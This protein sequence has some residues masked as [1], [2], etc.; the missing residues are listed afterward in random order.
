MAKHLKP[1]QRVTP[2]VLRRTHITMLVAAGIDLITIWSMVGHS[3][4]AMTQRYSGV[5]MESKHAALD[6]LHDLADDA[7]EGVD[8]AMIDRAMGLA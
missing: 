1:G 5:R 2:Q 3:S 7:L 4:V 8:A 6:T